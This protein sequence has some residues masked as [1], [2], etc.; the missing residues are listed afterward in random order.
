MEKII[1]TSAVGGAGKSTISAMLAMSLGMKGQKVLLID[2]NNGRRTQDLVFRVQD[3]VF[4]NTVDFLEGDYKIE[5]VVTKV[6]DNLFLLSATQVFEN[7]LLS[8]LESKLD[9]EHDYMIVDLPIE[10]YRAEMESLEDY[11]IL[12][13][14]D[15][16]DYS[17]RSTE[18]V[19]YYLKKNRI[20]NYN[21]VLNKIRE[22]DK[23][24]LDD[25]KIIE[26]VDVYDFNLLSILPYSE[27]AF[28]NSLSGGLL[29]STA[30]REFINDMIDNLEDVS[31][32]FTLFKKYKYN[33]GFFNRIFNR[34]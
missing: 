8:E 30:I 12:L 27:T 1:C 7:I 11:K 28:E 4:Y 22:Q 13:L 20:F 3:E 18:N 32:D 31:E 21:V 15:L 14:S 25:A 10:L 16:S 29:E 24:I 34:I 26:L 2:G 6:A 5:D 23:K 9:I 33:R 17:I 19:I